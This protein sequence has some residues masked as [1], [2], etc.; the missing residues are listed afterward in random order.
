MFGNGPI[1]VPS[2]QVKGPRPWVTIHVL[3]LYFFI[4]LIDHGLMEWGMEVHS[5]STPQYGV[6]FEHMD[7]DLLR[8]IYIGAYKPAYTLL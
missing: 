5:T 4:D 1:C 3:G 8:D 2:F 7:Y 6:L